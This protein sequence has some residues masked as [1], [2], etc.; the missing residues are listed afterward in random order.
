MATHEELES[1][2]VAMERRLRVVED[3][4]AITYLKARYGELVDER[5]ARGRPREAADLERIADEIAALFSEDAV[6]DAGTLGV[7][8]GRD[9]IRERMRTP[10]LHFSWHLFVMPRIQVEG[11]TV[12]RIDSSQ[13]LTTEAIALSKDGKLRV[14]IANLT[15]KLQTVT[16]RGLDAKR[17]IPVK[18]QPHAIARIN[19]VAD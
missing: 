7:C 2:L 12:Q 8:R 4:Q 17:A 15:D 19:R 16:L 1:R 13:P 10:T 5:Y 14:L 11:G 18:L 3:E 9:Q 6:W